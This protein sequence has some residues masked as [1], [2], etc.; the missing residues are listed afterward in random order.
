MKH[1]APLWEKLR[2]ATT[3]EDRIE[4]FSR[5]IQNYAGASYKPDIIDIIYER[6]VDNTV[7][8]HWKKCTKPPLSH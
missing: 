4:C 5:F 8:Y 2:D 1:F 6:I 3:D 7:N